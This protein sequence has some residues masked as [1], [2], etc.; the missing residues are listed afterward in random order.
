MRKT[1]LVAGRELRALFLSGVGPTVAVIFLALSGWTFTNSVFGTGEASL[2]LWA[3][4]V[5]FLLLPLGAILAMRTLAEEQRT[6]TIDLLLSSP[7]R[8]W[9]VVAGKYVGTLGFYTILLAA[10]VSYPVLLETWANPERG[11]FV[12]AYLGVWLFGAGAIAIG[13]FASAATSSQVVAA[14]A[15]IAIAI[16]TWYL[17][18]FA[19]Y[20]GGEGVERVLFWASP[21]PHLESFL[22]GRI[23]LRDA[24][25]YLSFVVFWLASGAQVL[26]RRL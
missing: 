3:N 12:G 20:V 21:S 2:T 5:Q 6:G 7:V 16:V 23:S 13:V 8:L 15:A 11:P 25:Y 22:L 18:S 9:Q 26:R 19:T 17:D 24:V 1:F 10:T 4:D 14:L